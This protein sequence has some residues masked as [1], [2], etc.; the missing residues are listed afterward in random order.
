MVVAAL[1]AGTA[2]FVVSN[3]QQKV[4]EAK[5]TLIVGQALSA[6][7]PDYTQ[8]LVAQNLSA[9]YAA[10][11][12]TRP[13]LESVI[14]D[15]GLETTPSELETRVAV[16]SPRDS[17]LLSITAQDTV[18]ARAAAIANALA[19]Q[20]IAVSPQIQGREAA[21]LKSIDQDL[22]ATQDLIEA[23]QVRADALIAVEDRTADQET[24]LQALEGRL[25]SLRSTYATLLSFSSG[26]ATN[27]LTVVEP[28]DTPTSNILPR[29]LLNTLLAACLG[30]L[31][32][33]GIAFLAEQLDDSIKDAEAVQEVTGLQHP[34]DDRRHEDH[35]GDGVSSIS[36]PSSSSR[37][38]ASPRRIA[39]CAR[40]SSSPRWMR[41]CGTLLVTSATPGE[42]KTVT[43]SN[44]AVVFAQAGRTVVLVDADLRKPG[45]HLMFDLPNIHGLTTLLRDDAVTIDAIAQATEQPNLRVLT[46]GPLPPNPA[47][48]L[49]FASHAGRP[50][51][52]AA[53]C[54]PRHLRQPATPGGHGR[55]GVELIRRTGRS[56]SS[57]RGGVDGG[58]SVWRRSRW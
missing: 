5:A 24:E 19:E 7:N 23:T 14:E 26:T 37:G 6:A 13:R 46:T 15:L 54:R 57:T 55:R 17:T 18:P 12:K 56:S 36:S 29:T 20:L 25:A 9:T 33:A 41:R 45:L 52:S 58:S 21:F 1:L 39:R 16:D 30:L 40:T 32:V 2:A 49:G 51:T 22:V 27:L 47:E 10:I 50:G 48:L 4:Y 34:G 38:R 53:E 43:A 28:A 31:V 8:F 42:G 3:L 35:A 44:L 11:A